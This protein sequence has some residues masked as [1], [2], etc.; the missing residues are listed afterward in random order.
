MKELYERLVGEGWTV[1]NWAQHDGQMDMA[2]IRH[3]N[4]RLI[5]AFDLR[6]VRIFENIEVTRCLASFHESETA[7]IDAYLA[8]IGSKVADFNRSSGLSRCEKCRLEHFDHPSH[9]E[10]TYLRVLCDGTLTKL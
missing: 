4:E 9:P 3:P 8:L 7:R 5:V 2:V 10:E 6:R 1:L